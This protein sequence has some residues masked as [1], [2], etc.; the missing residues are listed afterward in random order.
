MD[1]ILFS[2]TGYPVLQN[3]VYDSA[4]AAKLCPTGDIQ[5]VQ[6][7]STGLI[8]NKSFN[9]DL[10]SYDSNYDNEQ[11]CSIRFQEHLE[12]VAGIIQK[13]LGVHRLVEV[14]CGKGVFLEML[15]SRGVDVWGFDPTYT[16]ENRRVAKT[17]FMPGLI[18]KADG[19]ILRH[20]LEHIPNPV[21][22]IR[23]LSESNHG[24]G[25]IYIEVPCL[26]WII[27]KS[28]WQ[29]IFYE[30]VNY[31][32]KEDFYRI[33]SRVREIGHLFDG[34]YL[35]VVADLNSVQIPKRDPGD[36]FTFPTGFTSTLTDTVLDQPCGVWGAASKGVVFSLLKSRAGQIISFIIDINQSKQRMYLPRTG[37]EVLSPSMAKKSKTKDTTVYVMNPNYFREIEIINQGHFSLKVIND[38]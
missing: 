18:E 30:H 37:L 2:Q 24:Q 7:H 34:Q 21:S 6:D 8:Y 35:Y 32:R 23:E 19:L 36:R 11:A 9:P 27:R 26:D 3:R 17:L 29:D 16:G 13:K 4:E 12:E 14:G 25:L 1:K 22:F 15:L 38:E 5:I 20:V 33:F 28:A 10:I 31:F